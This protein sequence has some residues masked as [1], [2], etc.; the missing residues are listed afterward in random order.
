MSSFR[1]PL[2]GAIN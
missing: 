2:A 1:T